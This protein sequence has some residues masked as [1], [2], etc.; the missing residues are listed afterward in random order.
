MDFM[1]LWTL[2]YAERDL[3]SGDACYY[4]IK[5]LPS[6]DFTSMSTYG[7][8]FGCKDI[9]GGYFCSMLATPKKCTKAL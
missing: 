1:F 6:I 4:S 7:M 8:C 3:M 2:Q 9:K 5:T